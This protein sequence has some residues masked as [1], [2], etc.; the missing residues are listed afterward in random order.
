MPRPKRLKALFSFKARRACT[1]S[2]NWSGETQFWRRRN[3]RQCKHLHTP[4]NCRSRTHSEQMSCALFEKTW[5]V[6]PQIVQIRIVL[7]RT[8][9]GKV[10]SVLVHVHRED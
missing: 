6:Y 8:P 2:M 3:S 7:S 1:A 9:G 5:G 10:P 4:E